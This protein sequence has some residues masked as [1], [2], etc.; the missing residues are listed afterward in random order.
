MSA[1]LTPRPKAQ[2]QSICIAAAKSLAPKVQKWMETDPM[3]ISE[4][5]ADLATAIQW[6]SDGY[7]LA[8]ALDNY[9]PD[10][11]LVEILDEAS[12]HKRRA[13]EMAEKEWVKANNIQPIP[14][15]T[16]VTWSRK[17]EA[18]IGIVTANHADGKS[19]VLFESLGHVR[20]GI[21]SHGFVVEWE[22]L[23]VV[24]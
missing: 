17:P 14:L 2:D 13:L 24:K 22:K 5:E 10:A 9:S 3:D 7:E 20:S 1:P 16:R 12:C 8:C 15:E 23:E 21:G 11:A 6:C 4:I 19:T 18:G